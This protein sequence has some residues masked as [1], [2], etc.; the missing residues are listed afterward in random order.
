MHTLFAAFNL[1]FLPQMALT[2]T[3][4][5][6]LT[7]AIAH[8]YYPDDK[9]SI[10][11]NRLALSTGGLNLLL[12]PLGAIPM[13]HGAGGLVAYHTAGGR[14]GLPLI[15]LGL[16][17]L[18][19][20]LFTGPAASYYLD[21][22]PEATFGILLLI[23]ATYMVEPKKL[24]DLSRLSLLTVLLVVVVCVFYS[25]LAGLIAGVMFEYLLSLRQRLNAL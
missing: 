2:L 10:S 3:N 22:L 19:L 8:N 7:A 5:I 20:G 6:F 15:I 12:A 21:L 18:V 25:I 13:C 9:A 4:A 11:E 23:T 14:S 17:V 24:L 1:A 16:V